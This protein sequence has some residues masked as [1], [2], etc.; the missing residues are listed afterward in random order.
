MLLEMLNNINLWFYYH[1]D[2]QNTSVTT[3]P[4]TISK[5]DGLFRKEPFEELAL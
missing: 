3:S 1:L 5:G 4:A 2:L